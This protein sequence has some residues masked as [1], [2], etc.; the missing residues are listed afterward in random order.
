[1]DKKGALEKDGNSNN[2]EPVVLNADL[3]GGVS[4]NVKRNIEGEDIKN[5]NI[6]SGNE[7]REENMA[8]PENEIH[9]VGTKTHNEHALKGNAKNSTRKNKDLKHKQRSE[10]M[11]SKRAQTA[12]EQTGHEASK[13]K[14]RFSLKSRS[15]RNST[16]MY[17]E[18]KVSKQPKLGISKQMSVDYDTPFA[19]GR[20]TRAPGDRRSFIHRE[21][22]KRPSEE[23]NDEFDEHYETVGN[24]PSSPATQQ[25]LSTQNDT[26]SD[27]Y[28]SVD[29]AVM[30]E[31][32]SQARLTNVESQYESVEVLNTTCNTGTLTTKN[33]SNT[34][35]YPSG[36]YA[37]PDVTKSRS[38]SETCP[39][40]SHPQ[41]DGQRKAMSLGED[42][43]TPQYP[44]E[45]DERELSKVIEPYTITYKKGD[46]IVQETSSS[47]H[48]RI[49]VEKSPP[50]LSPDEKDK[51]YAK[52]DRE[53]Q[54]QDRLEQARHTGGTEEDEVLG[55][56]AS[57]ASASVPAGKLEIFFKGNNHRVRFLILG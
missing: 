22:P 46:N 55:E 19:L 41:A 31:G 17:E 26:A 34:Y 56:G 39:G 10:E 32:Q 51:L 27:L 30:V 4:G 23:R 38:L 45:E 3:K 42:T 57:E 14:T 52:V 50:E 8:N 43:R 48:V 1:M 18:P 9:E 47:D 40:P 21:L 20:P 5:G 28:D 44:A 33:V 35:E 15:S 37:V 53:K 29:D 25:V 16:K 2:R 11:R 7:I 12:P 24:V 13:G 36:E 54:K 49:P 6:E